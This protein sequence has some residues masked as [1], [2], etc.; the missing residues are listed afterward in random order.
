MKDASHSRVVEPTRGWWKV[1]REVLS[2]A[3]GGGR[4]SGEIGGGRSVRHLTLSAAR[5]PYKSLCRGG[6]CVVA[7]SLHGRSRGH[8]AGRWDGW[9]RCVAVCSGGRPLVT[10]RCDVV[11]TLPSSS[12]RF[13]SLK[14][15]QLKLLFDTF[16]EFGCLP[17]YSLVY[18]STV[19][20]IFDNYY[21]KVNFLLFCRSRT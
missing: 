5:G 3:L 20:L 18:I 12:T 1:G 8:D 21:S 17:F 16:F 15:H 6:G 14:N 13:F 10:T 2:A 19:C 9:H 11:V 7:T 4:T